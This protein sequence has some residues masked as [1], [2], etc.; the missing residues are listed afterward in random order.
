MPTISPPTHAD[1]WP[2]RDECLA[3]IDRDGFTILPH[4][5]PQGMIDCANA[6]IDECCARF[7]REERDHP[8]Y[9]ETNIVEHDPVFREFLL[10]LPALQLS[11]DVFGPMFHLGQDKWT[12]KF[13]ADE[14]M[15]LNWHSD[16]PLGF[17][18]IDGRCPLHTLR[19]GYFMSDITHDDSG[20][21]EEIRSN[22]RCG[23]GR[24]A[25][26]A[27]GSAAKPTPLK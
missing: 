2:R 6:Y 19:F 1:S 10:Y 16:G 24:A 23:G 27:G 18:E 9:T 14:G 21:L 12:R 4:L 8:R 5:L 15:S 13:R 17:P 3:A 7:D 20:T 25:A 22:S 11:Y 26:I